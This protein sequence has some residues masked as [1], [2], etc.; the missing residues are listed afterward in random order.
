MT[1]NYQVAHPFL[2][3]CYFVIS[4]NIWVPFV[5]FCVRGSLTFTLNPRFLDVL[6][7]EVRRV[8]FVLNGFH[9]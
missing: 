5:R 7:Q 2:G 9:Y 8:S 6:Q 1:V 4:Y 3:V